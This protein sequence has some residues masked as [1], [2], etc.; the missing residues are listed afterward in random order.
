VIQ[1]WAYPADLIPLLLVL[2]GTTAL[3]TVWLRIPACP[4]CRCCCVAWQV[5]HLDHDWPE[6]VQPH[7]GHAGHLRRQYG[8]C[9]LAV[10][11]FSLGAVAQPRP[12]HRMRWLVWWTRPL[13]KAGGFLAILS[14]A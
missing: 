5:L 11:V 7:P 9:G 8:R 14:A 3:V 1:G 6:R 10:H 4:M 12:F 13:L 2:A